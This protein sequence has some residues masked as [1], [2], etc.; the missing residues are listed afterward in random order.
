MTIKCPIC[1]E[2]NKDDEYE[3]YT[4]FYNHLKTH[5]DWL[6]SNYLMKIIVQ[7]HEKIESLQNKQDGNEWMEKE[8]FAETILKSILENDKK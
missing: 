2:V 5:P 7:V 4:E 3:V 1:M 8:F 6:L